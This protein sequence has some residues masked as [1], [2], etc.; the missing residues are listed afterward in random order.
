MNWI[1][2][3]I[4]IEGFWNIGKT[5]LAKELSKEFGYK[6]IYEPNHLEENITSKIEKWYIDQHR[7]NLKR[8]FS[9]PQQKTILERS[10]FSSAAFLYATNKFSPPVKKIISNF[11]NFYKQL[12]PLIIFLYAKD[13]KIQSISK[14]IEDSKVKDFLTKRDFRKKY[15]FFFRNILPFEFGLTPL[16]ISIERNNHLRGIKD[17]KMDVI[18]AMK[19]NRIAQVNLICYKIKNRKPYFLLLK[20]N[21]QKGNFWQG[22]TGG[23]KIGE[24]INKTLKRELQ[25]EIS[26][27]DK[28]KFLSTYYSFNYIGKEDYELNEYVFGCKLNIKDKIILSPEHTEYKFAPL[29]KCVSIL[30]YKS[31]KMAFQ[32]IY[33]MIKNKKKRRDYLL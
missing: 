13:K 10:T 17:I 6:I 5:S 2:N 33:S 4:V 21:S 3:K 15:D 20:R 14:S 8:S 28:K 23:V 26:I 16:F 11:I 29:K 24:T 9:Y 22:I 19:E 30:K 27:K 32:K 18:S 31:N 12:N 25:E 7:K 1:K